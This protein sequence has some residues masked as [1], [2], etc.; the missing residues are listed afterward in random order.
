MIFFWKVLPTF[1]V[2]FP[3]SIKHSGQS[4]TNAPTGQLDVDNSSTGRSTAREGNMVGM[5]LA[6][7]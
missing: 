5:F 1:G 4:L 7:P 3:T 2:G 6:I